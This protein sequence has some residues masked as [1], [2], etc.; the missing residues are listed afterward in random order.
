MR[1]L[2]TLVGGLVPGL[3]AG[4][5]LGLLVLTFL[6][7]LIL[8]AEKYE[9]HPGKQIAGSSGQRNIGTVLGAIIVGSAYGLILASAYELTAKK[10]PLRP[11]IR[12]LKF[13]L[14]GYF[15]VF[16]IPSLAF[17]PNPPGVEAQA[18]PAVRQTWWVS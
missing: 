12:G 10:P 18:L 3:A 15:I 5:I 11:I 14:L 6:T 8:S 17:L 4:L 16:F 1:F 7:P 9:D 13:G 2:S